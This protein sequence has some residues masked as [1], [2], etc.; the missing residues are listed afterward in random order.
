MFV[1]VVTKVSA[2]HSSSIFREVIMFQIDI[3]Q[4]LPAVRIPD[5]IYCALTQRKF[6][7]LVKRAQ[8]EQGDR[9][10]GFGV[11]YQ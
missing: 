1:C 3:V 11:L 8:Y 4:I 9:C 10:Q 5:L 7:G 2:K 6:Y